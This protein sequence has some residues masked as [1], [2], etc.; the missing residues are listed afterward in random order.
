MHSQ[1][2][3]FIPG[4]GNSEEILNKSGKTQVSTHFDRGKNKGQPVEKP[5]ESVN[6]LAGFIGI[7]RFFNIYSG[8]LFIEKRTFSGEMKGNFFRMQD[9]RRSGSLPP[10]SEKGLLT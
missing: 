5:V 7:P 10:P 3:I 6:N 2:I 4:D 1:C 9:L 8:S